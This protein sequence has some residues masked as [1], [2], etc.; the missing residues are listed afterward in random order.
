MRSRVFRLCLATWL[1][2]CGALAGGPL[3]ALSPTVAR[4]SDMQEQW[5]LLQDAQSAYQRGLLLQQRGDKPGAD[6]AFE[7]ATAGFQ[8][9]LQRNPLRTELYAPLGDI[10]VRRGQAAAAYGL[11]VKQTREGVT[12]VAVRVQLLRALQAMGKPQRAM[13]EA[14]AFLRA[15]PNT[16]ELWAAVGELHAQLGNTDQAIAD[17]TRAAGRVPATEW[18]LA[19][20]GLQVRK[21]LTR[22]LIERGR[23][24]EAL[25]LVSPLAHARPGD[26]EIQLLLGTALLRNSRAAEAVSSL[27]R[28]VKTA[29]GNQRA[30]A[31]LGQAL[32]DS[33]QIPAAIE[34]LEKGGDDPALLYS[35]AR[36]Y[37]RRQPPDLAAA[38]A[39]LER[40]AT[41]RPESLRLCTELASVLQQA[42]K[43]GP[44]LT[45]ISRCTASL[46]A[47][48]DSPPPS[49]PGEVV[50][51]QE[52]QQALVLRS[53][54]ELKLGK[55][56]DA[57]QTLRG[58][59]ARLGSGGP[60][61]ASLRGK[62]ATVL[63]RRGLAR[64]PQTPLAGNPGYTD[65]AEAHK[66]APTPQTG[67]ALALGMLSAGM[68]QDALQLLQPLAAA[69][70][71]DP[72]LLGALGRALRDSGQA[73]ESL[74]VLQKAEALCASTAATNPACAP[75]GS[76]RTTLKQEQAQTLIT[77]QKPMH[78]IK[79]LEGS[80]EIAQRLKA[81]ASLVAARQ[82]FTDSQ[83]PGQ[84]LNYTAVMFVTQQAL[85]AG[86]GVLPIQRAEAKLWQVLALFESG[87]RELG[88]KLL[89]EVAKL[90][91]AET[92][93][94]LMGPGGFAGLQARV[95]LRTGEFN[96]GVALA[97][98]AVTQLPADEARAL[99]TTVATAYTSKAVAVIARA[100]DG[101]ADKAELERAYTL[102]RFAIQYTQGGPPGNVLRATYNLAMLALF[103]GKP[104]EAKVLLSR[105]DPQALPE[106]HLGLGSYH[107]SI[108]DTRGALEAYRRYLQAVAA[109]TPPPA[110]VEKVQ[111]WVDLLSRVYE[112]AGRGQ[113]TAGH[114]SPGR[115]R[116]G[117]R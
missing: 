84:R 18:T 71:S 43:P 73:A 86:A 6:A 91:D 29:P 75:S 38:Q 109:V 107:D 28:Y 19:V 11:L 74:T 35:L 20:D 14:Q 113:P 72:R 36:L 94:A 12:D 62:L 30:V 51:L 31:L 61:A 93:Q 54:I 65:L 64:L 37:Q 41:A 108:G 67:Q 90:F 5:R 40:A 2:V 102:L 70:P 25:D 105:L 42:Q 117:S 87:Q 111:R 95:A 88:A 7:A 27:Q 83:K 8:A 50:S 82:L 58:A 78:S 15:A 69:S 57:V 97:Q 55:L 34:L 96:Q 60:L 100:T 16:P 110:P 23:A 76:L 106:V 4:A 77:L 89:A 26:S 85:K 98:Q 1:E 21:Q 92:L 59:Q 3:L 114:K 79:A 99:Q 66:L 63:M 56:D 68:T 103:R 10:M 53:D 39:V 47:S 22:L 104:E 32:A 112:G 116:G 101:K 115:R 44:A 49:A 46:L 48:A 80:D 45:E 33:G 13:E 9:V 52:I 17:L 81:Q 24:Q